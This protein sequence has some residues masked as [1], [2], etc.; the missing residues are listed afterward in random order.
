MN[1][2]EEKNRFFNRIT[3]YLKRDL[4]KFINIQV[5]MNFEREREKKSKKDFYLSPTDYAC[6][7]FWNV[8]FKRCIRI[9]I[10]RVQQR[11][12][13][14][15]KKNPSFSF[16]NFECYIYPLIFLVLST[17]TYYRYIMYFSTASELVW[18]IYSTFFPFFYEY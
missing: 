9:H 7:S 4:K 6:I 2:D 11:K 10:Q 5:I 14:E 15:K 16:Y 1:V 13:W 17:E 3:F 12:R 8:I 18:I